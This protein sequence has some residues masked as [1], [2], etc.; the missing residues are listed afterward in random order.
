MR[1]EVRDGKLHA[2][3][4]TFNFAGKCTNLRTRL[5]QN[6][7]EKSEFVNGTV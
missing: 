7:G 3:F 4:A 5:D 2:L 6:F 1:A